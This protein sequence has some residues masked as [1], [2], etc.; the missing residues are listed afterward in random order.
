MTAAETLAL[1]DWKRRVFALYAA[2]RV[3]EP[4]SGWELWRETRDELF[5]SHPQS[6]RPG[7]AE[8]A[9][10]I[11]AAR[12]RRARVLRLRPRGACPR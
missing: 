2:V 9:Y 6:P 4:E 3:M 12:L 7:Y 5:R 10:P 1:L 8:L 11:A